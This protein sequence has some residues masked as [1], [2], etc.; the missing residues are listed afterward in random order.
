MLGE[1]A[2]GARRNLQPHSGRERGRGENPRVHA[3]PRPRGPAPRLVGFSRGGPAKDKF[4]GRNGRNRG[5]VNLRGLSPRVP[6]RWSTTPPR[7]L[8]DEERLGVGSER[9]PSR[10]GHLARSARA[11]G[12]SDQRKYGPGVSA[13]YVKPNGEFLHRGHQKLQAD[14]PGLAASMA[15]EPGA[16]VR[17][18]QK[19]ASAADRGIVKE[20]RRADGTVREQERGRQGPGDTA[21][22]KTTNA[23]RSW[24]A[25]FSGTKTSVPNA[26]AGG[27]TADRE[28]SSDG[29]SK[30][31][32]FSRSRAVRP[33]TRADRNPTVRHAQ[34]GSR[35]AEWGPIRA[36]RACPNAHTAFDVPN[37]R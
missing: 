17:A 22:Q 30:A 34:R 29:R 6:E 32:G 2:A 7:Q 1:D 37:K 26:V 14:G 24:P 8:R 36:V 11:L 5:L 19:P 35:L 15:G 10:L 33:G 25:C 28:H 23:R 27:A 18:G 4:A 20:E 9:K 16:P 12:A 31:C 13:D 21:R 3:S